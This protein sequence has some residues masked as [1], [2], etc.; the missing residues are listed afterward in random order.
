[1][2]TL[3]C[4]PSGQ[5]QLQVVRR[6]CGVETAK[7]N[8]GQIFPFSREVREM[9]GSSF[10]L[11]ERAEKMDVDD[12]DTA[13]TRQKLCGP[14]S[15]DNSTHA[16]RSRSASRHPRVHV[17]RPRPTISV[18]HCHTRLLVAT[19]LHFNVLDCHEA[20]QPAPAISR[21]SRSHS[22]IEREFDQSRT[23]HCHPAH[24][25]TPSI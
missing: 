25:L 12:E 4:P 17:L 16:S 19:A 14:T 5:R 23:S 18:S 10:P 20:A 6:E 24:L 8:H 21:P 15:G 3:D 11:L 1:M 22:H 13:G 9:R 7:V 2:L